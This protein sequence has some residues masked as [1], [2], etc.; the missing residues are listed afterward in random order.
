MPEVATA[1]AAHPASFRDRAGRVFEAKGEIL[2]A[3]SP[4]AA[5]EFRWLRDS[6]LLESL[7]ESGALIESTELDARRFSFEQGIENP[8]LVLR[9]PRIPFISHPYEW[10]FRALQCAAIHHLELHLAALEG[11]ANL[12]DATAYNIQFRGASPVFIDVSSL[13]RYRDGELW[14]GH[15]QFCEQFLNPLLLEAIVGVPFQNWYRGCLEGIPADQL[16]RILPLRSKLNWRVLA[17][18]VMQARLQ[19]AASQKPVEELGSAARRKFPRAGLVSML[20]QLLKWIRK[21]NPADLKAST[22]SDYETSRTYDEPALQAKMGFVSEFVQA[23]KPA[24]MWDLGCNA[25]EYSLAALRS[26]AGYVVGFDFDRGALDEAFKR[27]RQQ[28]AN[29]LPLL[30]DAA[31]PSPRQGWRQSERAGVQ[32][33]G[34]CD[35]LL[36]L[37]FEH[38]LTIAR[39]VPIP[40]FLDWLTG[41]GRCGVVEFVEKHDSTVQKMLALRED[42]FDDY[43]LANF[44]QALGQRAR[45][46]KRMQLPGSSRHLFWY[47]R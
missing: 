17:H 43:S 39:N 12:T 14:L 30:L 4:A 27:S 33:R 45:I 24:M 22:W 1:A 44:E 31:N 41:L 36:A 28:R 20:R 25:G 3:L 32:E 29:F 11:G 2:R 42:V 15:R 47:E 5:E 19:S 23:T 8:A 46:V 7:V 13:R 6:G 9:H 21:L 16:A 18:V 26:G 40:S 38:H 34:P 10:P 35:A 37:A